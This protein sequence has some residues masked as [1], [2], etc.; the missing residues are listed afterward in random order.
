MS[1][2]DWKRL[3]RGELADRLAA[4]ARIAATDDDRLD[5]LGTAFVDEVVRSGK[6]KAALD[7]AVN[8]TA[9]PKAVPA[10]PATKGSKAK[11]PRELILEP[12]EVRGAIPPILAALGR[13][14][15]VRP[16]LAR[17]LFE[18]AKLWPAEREHALAALDDARVEPEVLA[19]GTDAI[20]AYAAANPDPGGDI[21]RDL[22][23]AWIARPA[24]LTALL[25]RIA[26]DGRASDVL[27]DGLYGGLPEPGPGWDA[28][29]RARLLAWALDAPS[30]ARAFALGTLATGDDG[31]GVL[32]VV[33]A[34]L[35]DPAAHARVIEA[36][37]RLAIARRL[38]EPRVLEAAERCEL[39]ERTGDE[40][41]TSDMTEAV[42]AF[43]AAC[44][45]Q[46]A[47]PPTAIPGEHVSVVEGRFA[48][49]GF[50]I[51][52]ELT[53][54]AVRRA[55]IL[56]PET[57]WST[58]EDE[59]GVAIVGPGH[60]AYHVA[61]VRFAM[62]RSGGAGARREVTLAGVLDGRVVVVVKSPFSDDRGWGNDNYALGVAP[63]DGMWLAYREH[64]GRLVV[65]AELPGAVD[66]TELPRVCYGEA[67]V[68]SDPDG[69]RVVADG[70]PYHLDDW[71]LTDEVRAAF[72]ARDAARARAPW[73]PLTDD[74]VDLASAWPALAENTEGAELCAMTRGADDVVVMATGAERSAL[75]WL[76]R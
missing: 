69:L 9:S 70:T 40:A 7:Q 6:V 53:A 63:R 58:D 66:E 37:A 57:D 23:T 17:W 29:N 38:F 8:A 61:P 20:V 28:E 3:A 65:A 32:E 64:A 42:A 71:E 73:Q 41:A 62:R 55:R 11:G 74:P 44:R 59:I 2:A 5:V 46:L 56:A 13:R 18:A 4:L 21:L 12:Y 43:V 60:A 31:D 15:H 49:E 68:W 19:D 14:S 16:D 67:I 72:E 27:A 24:W 75:I 10:R 50:A 48:L 22:A 76:R 39:E 34:A 26:V 36:A 51:I 30:G 45:A 1:D 35:A 33:V 47:P 54:T 25:A 52:D